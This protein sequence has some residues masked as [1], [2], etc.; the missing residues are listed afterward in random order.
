LEVDGRRYKMH[1]YVPKPLRC[2]KCQQF[3]HSKVFC[4][5][6]IVCSRCSEGHSYAECPDKTNLKCANCGQG[7]SSAY[8][9]CPLYVRTHAALKL[10]AEHNII[11]SD[12]VAMVDEGQN[13]NYLCS[14]QNVLKTYDMPI[15]YA[16]KVKN[17]KGNQK[18]VASIPIDTQPPTDGKIPS[19]SENPSDDLVKQFLSF[20][21]KDPNV[22]N[23][24]KKINGAEEDAEE[25]DDLITK[26]K[27]FVLGVLST[28]GKAKSRKHAQFLIWSAASAIFFDNDSEFNSNDW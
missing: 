16:S 20:S 18:D 13:E 10:R 9:D 11:F 4:K 14:T 23:I 7:H 21:D 3:G 27:S 19:S 26:L 22:T 25:N 17:V 6:E 8:R 15:T 2:D 12:A 24:S 5:K 28:I 1:P